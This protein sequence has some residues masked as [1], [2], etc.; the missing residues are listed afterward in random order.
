MVREGPFTTPCHP[1]QS[2]EGRLHI[3]VSL[4]LCEKPVLFFLLV[5]KGDWGAGTGLEAWTFS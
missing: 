1:S 4:C 3:G 2:P 5:P